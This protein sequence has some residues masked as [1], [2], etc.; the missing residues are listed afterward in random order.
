MI[1][2]FADSIRKT[3]L[4][5]SLFTARSSVVVGVSGGADSIALLSALVELREL[6]E[7]RVVAAHLDHAL[8]S[9]SA[10]DAVFTAD[11][12][13]ALGVELHTERLPWGDARRRPRSNIEARSREERYAFLLRVAAKERAMVAVA[14]HADDV[15]E[16]FLAQ[17]IRGAGPRGLSHPRFRRDDGIIRPLLEK[18]RAEILEYLRERK[19]AHR[20]DPTNVDGSN[21]RSRLRTGVIP[22]L[23]REN[24][25]VARATVRTARVL[26]GLDDAWTE[27]AGRLLDEMTLRKRPGEIVLDASRGHTYDPTVLSTILRESLTRIGSGLSDSGFESLAE[28][29]AAWRDQSRFA[30]DL[31][32]GARIVVASDVVRV[33]KGRDRILSPKSEIHLQELPIPG[34]LHWSVPWNETDGLATELRGS[35]VTPVPHNVKEISAPGVAWLDAD[36]VSFPLQ[37]RVRRPGDRY[38]PLGLRGTAKLHDLLIDRKVP[39]EVRDSLPVV[40]DAKGIVWVPGLRVDER[41]KITRRTRRA[42]RVEAI[43]SV[44][45]HQGEPA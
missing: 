23:V 1:S 36:R 37:V 14:H 35:L 45:V 42:V 21:L 44:P 3:I 7:I 29:A 22:L 13:R 34:K 4:R 9:D 12:A 40:L 24:P 38:R 18:T 28:V 2:S 31:P 19:L 15:L 41:T 11:L 30:V 43:P 27:M 6:L 39:R 5:E 26:A 25:A 10:D 33:F 32:H 17:L 8:R 16:T 20:E